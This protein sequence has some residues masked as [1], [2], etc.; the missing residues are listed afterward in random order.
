MRELLKPKF[1]DRYL[2][3]IGT[4]KVFKKFYRELAY[5]KKGICV[6]TRLIDTKTKKVVCELGDKDKEEIFFR[7]G[8]TCSS[9]D[10]TLLE[11]DRNTKCF[12]SSH[13]TMDI[14]NVKPVKESFEPEDFIVADSKGLPCKVLYIER[15]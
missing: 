15:Y 13:Y 2:D 3:N 1:R 11:L 12:L 14:F 10:K 8:L 4:F 5:N 7:I 6:Y 9:S